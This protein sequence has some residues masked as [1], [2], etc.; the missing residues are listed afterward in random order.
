[1]EKYGKDGLMLGG[2]SRGTMT[3]ANG[4]YAAN[5]KEN[6]EKKI[7]SDTKI[8]MVGAAANITRA[9]TVLSLLQ[10]GEERSDSNKEGSIRVENHERD[11][12]SYLIGGN[13]HTMKDNH[14]E[15]GLLKIWRYMLGTK[16]SVHNCI[17]LGN[18][19]CVKDGY[20][21]EGDLFM[22]KEKTIYELNKT[23]W[24]SD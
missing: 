18:E 19:Q 23:K 5:T 1:M 3:L 14:N 13:P 11:F 6:R 2:H 4:L 20:R 17:G 10:T 15:H 16:T 24:G 22:D 21:K 12:V 9:D 7:L 8:K